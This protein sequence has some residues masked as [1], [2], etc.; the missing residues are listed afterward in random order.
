YGVVDFLWYRRH[1]GV[2]SVSSPGYDV[3]DEWGRPIRDPVRWPSSLGGQGFKIVADSLNKM[4]LKFGIHVMREIS[5]E[6]VKQNTPI[7]GSK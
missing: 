7:M 2:A 6:A 1:E 4:D 3:I 5:S